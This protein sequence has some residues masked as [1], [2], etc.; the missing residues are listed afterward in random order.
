MPG[1]PVGPRPASG[2]DRGLWTVLVRIR[3][4]SALTVRDV[5]KRAGISHAMVHYH[6]ES[7]DELDPRRGGVRAGTTR[8]PPA[9]G[10]RV[11]P[12][13]ARGEAR[14][15]DRVDGRTRH[16]R[17][18]AGPPTVARAE[19]VERTIASLDGRR[20]RPLARDLRGSVPSIEGVGL[21][22]TPRSTSDCSAQGSRRCP[23]TWWGS[24]ASIPR[25]T[26]T[27]SCARCCARCSALARTNHGEPGQV[28][29]TLRA[30]RRRSHCAEF[31]LAL[32]SGVRPLGGRSRCVP[33]SRGSCSA[34]T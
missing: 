14:A 30:I 27:R 33:R 11:R 20:V 7:K 12:W 6:F 19:R 34:P 25:S 24:S 22:R 32:E 8:I 4:L 26:P 21:V 10:H 13:Y 3:G 2:P 9:R 23:T 15:R 1:K 17:R 5:A 28:C 16:H 31:R 18:D 29:E